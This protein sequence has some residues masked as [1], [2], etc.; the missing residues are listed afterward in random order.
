MPLSIKPVLM[1]QKQKQVFYIAL[2]TLI[3]KHNVAGIQY[4]WQLT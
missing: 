1:Y 3:V 4:K 2:Q